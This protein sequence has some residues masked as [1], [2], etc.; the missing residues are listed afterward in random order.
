MK[1]LKILIGT[2]LLL[3]IGFFALGLVKP[4]IQYD[5]EVTINKP[6]REVWAVM[7]DESKMAD[8]ISG[9]ISS[10]LISGTSNTVGAV[11]KINVEENGQEMSMQETITAITPGELLS[12]DFT[13]DMMD[14]HYTLKLEN[15]GSS[16]LVKTSSITKG[17]GMLYKSIVALMPAAMQAQEVQ[18]LN[19]LKRLVETNT[20]NYNN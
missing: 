16:T 18:N 2:I 1:I 4:T 15:K 13:M 9:Y 3:T 20:T 8:W 7:S 5:C 17:N 19:N 6:A 12:M 10:E 11:T 14:M